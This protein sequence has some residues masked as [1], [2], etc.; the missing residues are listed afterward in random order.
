MTFFLYQS[1]ML[2]SPIIVVAAIIIGIIQ[3]IPYLLDRLITSRLSRVSTLLAT[4]IFPLGKVLSEYLVTLLLPFGSVLSLAYTQHDNLPLLQLLAV[5]GTYGIS[6]LMAW[7]A[8]VG[9]Y[10]WERDFSWP[11]VRTITVLYGCLLVLVL[12]GGSIRLAFFAPSAPTI[13]VAGISPAFT[14]RKTEWRKIIQIMQKE[15]LSDTD[16]SALHSSIAAMNEPLFLQSQREAQA[17]AKIVIWPESA[18]VTLADEE[19]TLFERSKALAQQEGIYLE[20]GYV[21]LHYQH[22]LQITQ[23]R[24]ALF[25]PQGHMSWTYDKAHPIPGMEDYAPGDGKVPAV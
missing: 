7:F 11:R 6:F 18:A 17:G 25:D 3:S 14:V 5:T 12:L 2:E 23:N 13:R 16:F 20:I 21:V 19:T 9:N 22:S 8:S 1:Q 24:T 4:L 10:L 15:Q